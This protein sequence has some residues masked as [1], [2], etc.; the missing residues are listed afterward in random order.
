MGGG[1]SRCRTGSETGKSNIEGIDET[2]VRVSIVRGI[3]VGIL[4]SR[5]DA[6]PPPVSTDV[7][8]PVGIFAT[9]GRSAVLGA[10]NPVMKSGLS[11]LLNALIRSSRS[12]AFKSSYFS[13]DAFAALSIS[14]FGADFD[15]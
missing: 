2:E 10:A 8:T 3:T 5:Q 4:V 13:V 9:E 1:G 12:E 7:V 6:V 11:Y 14:R 15:I